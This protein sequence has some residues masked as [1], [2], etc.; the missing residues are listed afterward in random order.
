MRR[1]YKLGERL[2]VAVLIFTVFGKTSSVDAAEVQMT[3]YI[4]IP[5]P[6]TS[7]A[8]KAYVYNNGRLETEI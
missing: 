8:Q 5:Y 1:K 4:V 7:A 3:D 6:G 2:I